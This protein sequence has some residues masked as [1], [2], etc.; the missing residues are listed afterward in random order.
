[1]SMKLLFQILL[2]AFMLI[3]STLIEAGETK[4]MNQEWQFDS[5]Q[6][7]SKAEE[8]LASAREKDLSTPIIPDQGIPIVGIPSA[9]H[10]TSL[11]VEKALTD[12]NAETTKSAIV[13]TL[14]SDVLFE[15]GKA[16]ISPKAA[17]KLAELGLIIKKKASGSVKI[18]GHTDAKGS[19]EYNQKLSE[20]RALAVKKWLIKH[21]G[22]PQDQ[23]VTKGWGE[24]KPI[25]PN[26][27]P[28]GSDNPAGRAKNRRVVITIPTEAR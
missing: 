11:D 28:D 25:A 20:R 3:P 27:Y 12:L 6:A 16:D 24:S 2:A 13:I 7:Q 17:A 5:Q 10:S 18:E 4:D 15:F 26:T 22:I 9:V 1:M 14:E 21:Q 23:I 19:D 8:A